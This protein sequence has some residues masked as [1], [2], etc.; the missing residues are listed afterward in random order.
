MHRR[1]P[2]NFPINDQLVARLVTSTIQIMVALGMFG[3]KKSTRVGRA[4]FGEWYFLF[5]EPIR[6]SV[7]Q[8]LSG[9]YL[10]FG[11]WVKC[12]RSAMYF[13]IGTEIYLSIVTRPASYEC[14]L[15]TLMYCIS[16]FFL[17]HPTLF[18]LEHLIFVCLSIVVV[19]LYTIYNGSMKKKITEGIGLPLT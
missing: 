1:I 12:L 15:C 7:C 17:N 14:T 8:F 11:K 9:F 10:V 6:S 13:K 3:D 16:I 4:L 2:D 19:P 18:R 5:G